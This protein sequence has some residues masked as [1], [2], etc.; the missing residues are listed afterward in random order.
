MRIQNGAA[1]M[2]NS[3]EALQNSTELSYDPV[4]HHLCP[5]FKIIDSRIFNRNLHIHVNSHITQTAKRWKQAKCM[6]E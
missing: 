1:I 6:N 4:S 5:L 3:T 2:K